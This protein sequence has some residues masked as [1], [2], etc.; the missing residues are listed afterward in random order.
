M[1]PSAHHAALRSHVTLL[2]VVMALL[3]GAATI[4]ESLA[5]ASHSVLPRGVPEGSG[6]VAPGVG[7]KDLPTA[8]LAPGCRLR[9]G[10]VGHTR[11]ATRTRQPKLV[12]AA[13]ATEAIT[14]VTSAQG[15]AAGIGGDAVTVAVFSSPFCGP[16]LLMEPVVEKIAGDFAH[17]GLNVLKLSL[18]PGKMGASEEVKGIFSDFD[19]KELPA[20]L[21]FS[22][23]E[24]Q[25]RITGTRSEQLRQA[26][27]DLL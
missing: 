25:K 17:Q 20:F 5:L 10:G 14:E 2:S 13:T 27:A 6:R 7:R 24:L 22:G 3:L 21:V 16:C 18:V 23:G 9:R 1:A 4:F 19:V 26:V 15:F 12:L 8:W 11:A